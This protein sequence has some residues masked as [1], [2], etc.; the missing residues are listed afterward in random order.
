MILEVIS[1][2]AIALLLGGVGGGILGTIAGL[3]ITRESTVR[4]LLSEG[5]AVHALEEAWILEGSNYQSAKVSDYRGQQLPTEPRENE[6]WLRPVEIRAILDQA[7]W[8]AP[9]NQAFGF[10]GKGRTWIV[11]NELLAE[12]ILSFPPLLGGTYLDPHPALASSRGLYELCGWI[13]KVASA[14]SKWVLSNHALQILR[15]LLEAVAGD[16]RAQVLSGRL[17]D[18][19]HRFLRKYRK[20]YLRSRLR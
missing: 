7:H 10:I 18:T 6:L 4:M 16:D 13:E 3:A 17:T 1:A 15:P 20:K 12:D 19:A 11:R 9:E 5:L 14:W 8:N 2:Q